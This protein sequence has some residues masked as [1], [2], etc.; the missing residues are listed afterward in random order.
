M[1]ISYISI[2]IFISAIWTIWASLFWYLNKKFCYLMKD[3]NW[4]YMTAI[5][6]LLD[7]SIE[8]KVIHIFIKIKIFSVNKSLKDIR[9]RFQ[10]E[11]FYQKPNQNVAGFRDANPVQVR[12]AYLERLIVLECKKFSKIIF[13]L[14]RNYQL[15]FFNY[16]F[17]VLW[18]E[19]SFIYQNKKYLK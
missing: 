10:R 15:L 16:A 14:P 17:W 6:T 11:F 2:S 1:F 7:V 3:Q 9:W 13:L 18:E 5:T 19:V 8:T 4:I 12:R